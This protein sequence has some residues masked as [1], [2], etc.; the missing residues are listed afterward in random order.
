MSK[1]PK[2]DHQILAIL[3]D[4]HLF[5]DSDKQ[6]GM[7]FRVS[8]PDKNHITSLKGEQ[9]LIASSPL[10]NTMLE[11]EMRGR[12][13]FNYSFKILSDAVTSKMLFRMDEG[14]GTH[15]NRHLPVPVNQQQVLTPHFHK[16]GDDGIMY[17]YSTDDLRQYP[18]PLNIYDGFIAFCK[19]SH[20]KQDNIQI[21]IHESGTLPFEYLSEV[22]PLLN[23]QFP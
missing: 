18:T 20:I 14:S 3:E 1:H 23:I 13:D 17:A 8:E 21:L 12:S 19:E 9:N 2:V 6:V 16:V 4:Y 7:P 15:W 22:D 10:G 5:I 11:C